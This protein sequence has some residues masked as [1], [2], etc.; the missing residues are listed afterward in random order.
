MSRLLTMII[1]VVPICHQLNE[2]TRVALV[3]SKYE[4]SC[5]WML[6]V[7]NEGFVMSISL[8][9]SALSRAVLKTIMAFF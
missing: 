6:E 4:L 9:R 3:A 5:R 7:S 2:Q 1:H 8:W